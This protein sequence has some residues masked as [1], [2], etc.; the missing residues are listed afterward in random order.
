MQ[1]LRIYPES[2]N[3]EIA[4]RIELYS[5]RMLFLLIYIIFTLLYEKNIHNTLKRKCLLEFW[6]IYGNSPVANSKQSIY[7][8]CCVR[9]SLLFTL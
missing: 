7:I 9:L 1:K 3:N 5:N 6:E 2:W 8:Q 4:L